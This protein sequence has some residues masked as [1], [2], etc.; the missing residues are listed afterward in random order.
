MGIGALSTGK[1]KLMSCIST[2][3]KSGGGWY[4]GTNERTAKTQRGR[5]SPIAALSPS[6]L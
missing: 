1:E 2:N 6:Q 5:G 3:E 4:E